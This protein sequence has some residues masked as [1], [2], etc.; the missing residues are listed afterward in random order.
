MEYLSAKK[1]KF[2]HAI[3]W[4]NLEDIILGRVSQTHKDKCCMIPLKNGKYDIY[5]F[6]QLKS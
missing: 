4:M 1:M 2:I 6:P 3:T 5:I